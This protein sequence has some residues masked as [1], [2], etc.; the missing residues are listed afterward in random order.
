MRSKESKKWLTFEQLIPGQKIVW[1]KS[2][3][4]LISPAYSFIKA[5]EDNTLI[6][7]SKFDKSSMIR[8]TLPANTLFEVYLSEEE[9]TNK[10]HELSKPL[11][12]ILKG[13]EYIGDKGYHSMDNS[14]LASSLEELYY[15]LSLESFKLIG[16]FSL[17]EIKHGFFDDSDIGIILENSEGERFWC[18]FKKQSID[19]MT[20]KYEREIK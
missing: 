7:T 17:P 6:L 2:E 4:K 16:W 20:A 18:H 13:P 19:W 11:Y 1:Y 14:W 3:G 5:V 8:L 15:N 12:E 9:F 10:Y